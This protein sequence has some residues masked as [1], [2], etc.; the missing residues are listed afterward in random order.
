MYL[1]IIFSWWTLVD[2]KVKYTKFCLWTIAH[3]SS[4]TLFELKSR[5]VPLAHL[6]CSQDIHLLLAGQSVANSKRLQSFVDYYEDCKKCDKINDHAKCEVR[7][8][9]R[10]MNANKVWP[11][12]IFRQINEFHGD[13][14][15]KASARK[16]CIMFNGR[17][18][19][20]HDEP[21]FSC[22]WQIHIKNWE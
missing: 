21:T 5:A 15:N 16:W 17:R 7:S 1:A 18:A 12:E 9:I 6:G 13:V 10:F 14:I 11:I 19:N 3:H 20:D 8:V 22:D 2:F 4:H